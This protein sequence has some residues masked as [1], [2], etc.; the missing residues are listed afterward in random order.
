MDFRQKSPARLGNKGKD[1]SAV[2]TQVMQRHSYQFTEKL[3]SSDSKR[4]F[5]GPLAISMSIYLIIQCLLHL[6]AIKNSECKRSRWTE[7][8]DMFEIAVFGI[9]VVTQTMKSASSSSP[10][11]RKVYALCSCL[12]LY[13]LSSSLVSLLSRESVVCNC[14]Q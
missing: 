10:F 9:G 3:H 7:F 6:T 8:A 12:L 14:L 2:S 11:Y 4:H 1:G 5:L 13:S